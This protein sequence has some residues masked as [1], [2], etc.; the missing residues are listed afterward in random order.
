MNATW[1]QNI[2]SLR[3]KL[4]NYYSIARREVSLSQEGLVADANM[5]RSYVGGIERGEYNINVMN[6]AKLADALKTKPSLLLEKAR[7]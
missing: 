6:V 3:P 4:V 2:L 7:L 1:Q 5:D